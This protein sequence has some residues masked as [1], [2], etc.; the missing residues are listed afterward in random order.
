[1]VMSKDVLLTRFLSYRVHVRAHLQG[2]LWLD[3]SQRVIVLLMF[4][5]IAIFLSYWHA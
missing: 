1:M 4:K 3:W 2:W 5:P